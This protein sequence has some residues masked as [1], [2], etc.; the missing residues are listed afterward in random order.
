M[1]RFSAI[2]IFLITLLLSCVSQE[3]KDVQRPSCPV[4]PS[5]V[6]ILPADG[7]D[8]NV[9]LAKAI[10]S[11]LPADTGLEPLSIDETKM[12]VPSYPDMEVTMELPGDIY[13]TCMA[14][15]L[16]P[17]QDVYAAKIFCDLRTGY[18]IVAWV[19]TVHVSTDPYLGFVDDIEL[20]LYAYLMNRNRNFLSLAKVPVND[21]LSPF[22]SSAKTIESLLDDAAADIMDELLARRREMQ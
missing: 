6:A 4:P 7:H 18:L 5:T 19:K 22:R 12:A 9:R 2:A 15:H 10:R 1:W 16:S 21:I 3:K 14:A 20:E 13:S 8:I 17:V 11:H